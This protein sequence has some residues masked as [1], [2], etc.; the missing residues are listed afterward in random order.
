MIRKLNKLETMAM[1]INLSKHL[2]QY[3]VKFR[4]SWNMFFTLWN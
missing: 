4:N 2:K 1:R 3:Q